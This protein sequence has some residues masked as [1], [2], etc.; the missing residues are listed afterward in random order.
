MTN[1]FTK[2]NKWSKKERGITLVALVVTVVV[3]LILA[4]ISLA[5]VLGQNGI[6]TKATK[7]GN[8]T[9]KA[10]AEERVQMIVAEYTTDKQT[11]DTTDTLKNYV[12]AKRAID[13]TDVTDVTEDTTAN[14]TT[15]TVDGYKVTVNSSLQIASTEGGSNTGTT[16]TTWNSTQGV[17]KPVLK[18]GMTPVKWTSA[19]G[20]GETATTEND[21]NWYNYVAQASGVDQTSY[22]A[23]AKTAD[24]SYWVWIPRYEY[25]I[26]P[27]PS[28]TASDTNAGTIDVKF[29]KTTQAADEGYRIHPAFTDDSANGYENGGWDSELAGIWVM[30]YEASNNGG[31][32][33][34]KPSVASWTSITIGN[35]YTYG[36]AYDT[37]SASHMMKNSEWGAVAYLTHSQYGRNGNQIYINN[38]SSYITGNSGGSINAS[39]TSSGGA[40]YEYNTANGVKA[41][42]TGNISGIYD[43]S[44]GAYEYV[45]AFNNTDTGNYEGQY[46]SSF[47]G[48]SKSS[49]RYATKYYNSAATYSGSTI[50][51]V[52]KKGDCLAEVYVTSS[53]GWYND[54]LYFAG[55]DS[56][57]FARGGCYGWGSNA[58]VFSS[59]HDSGSASSVYSFRVVLV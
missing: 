47:A 27:A 8:D 35:M 24:G 48:T 55:A 3:L 19:I 20:A 12:E 54:Y 23:N 2:T 22:W 57:F 42:S 58:G 59:N 17:N 34:S 46:G 5:L 45:A 9:K 32:A 29:I 52:S 31:K 36:L 49:T 7:A 26:T 56:P 18:T 16:D 10:K 40:T 6:V 21:E 13:Y 39:A 37:T 33:A 53:Y 4:G 28:T 43:L 50:S 44:G 30:K 25:K 14:T 38:S 1:F 41:S 11:G 15:I 51:S